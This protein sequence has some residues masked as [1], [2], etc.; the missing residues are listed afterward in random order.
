M[1]CLSGQL[2]CLSGQLFCTVPKSDRVRGIVVLTLGGIGLGWGDSP[3]GWRQSHQLSTRSYLRPRRPP[4]PSPPSLTLWVGLDV[5]K[6][7]KS[8]KSN[9]RNSIAPNPTH[10]RRAPKQ[11]IDSCFALS[12]IGG[13]YCG[14]SNPESA[15]KRPNV[16][17]RTVILGAR[18]SW[19]AA[20]GI[21]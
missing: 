21:H 7:G 20:V 10:F 8:T 13:P 17:A 1:V 19:T 5:D 6:L 16:V 11:C 2:F 4:S 9:F 14:A 18:R 15:R 3:A 12:T